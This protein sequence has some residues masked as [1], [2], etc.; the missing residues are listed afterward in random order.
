MQ[1]LIEKLKTVDKKVWIGVGIGAAVL[2]I[3]IIALVIGSGDKPAGNHG[4]SQSGT[5]SGTQLGSDSDNNS[6][7]IFGSEGL[8]TE[9]LGTEMGTEVGTEMG[10]EI[11]GSETENGNGGQNNGGQS[12]GNSGNGNSGNGNS[13]NGSSN[14]NA[15]PVTSEKPD[16]VNGVEQNTVTTKPNGE[17]ILG[18]GTKDEPYQEIPN[19]DTMSVETISIP[20]GGTLYYSIQRIGGKWLTIEDADAYVI[21]SD[22]KTRHDAKNGKVGFTVESAMSNENVLLQIGNK[23]TSAK[24]FTIKFIDIVGTYPKPEKITSLSGEKS[25]EAGDEDGYYYKYTATKTGKIRF[26]I[27]YTKDS[28]IVVSNLTTSQVRNFTAD[29]TGAEYI[30]LDVK[31]GDEVLIQIYAIPDK[32]HRYPATT[33]T[34]RGEYA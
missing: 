24:V 7:E 5:Q 21:E 18:A 13:G 25:L 16:D 22:G 2:I 26:Y 15:G 34:W 32:R 12:N 27:S 3:L 31:A 9:V 17:K 1:K 30:E 29:D 28:D 23:G 19:L 11:T 14:N 4:G 20:A 33:I 6:S 10:T 8:G